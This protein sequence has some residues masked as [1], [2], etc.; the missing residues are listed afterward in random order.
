MFCSFA[1]AFQFS[2]VESDGD[3]DQVFNQEDSVLYDKDA[4]KAAQ[5]AAKVR[6]GVPL[7]NRRLNLNK[8]HSH[9]DMTK[10]IT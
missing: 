7:I 5:E 1:Y 10:H 8:N 6:Q 4:V 9:T 3:D 2:D